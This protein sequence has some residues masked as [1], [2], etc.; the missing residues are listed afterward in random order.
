MKKFIPLLSLIS[1]AVASTACSVQDK[2]VK[3]AMNIDTFLA[4]K[5]NEYQTPDIEKI[6]ANIEINQLQTNNG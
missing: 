6:A 4:D 5:E 2:R 1:I 3:L